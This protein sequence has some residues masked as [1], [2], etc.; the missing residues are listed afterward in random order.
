MCAGVF[1]NGPRLADPS[2]MGRITRVT[3]RAA[4]CCLALLSFQVSMARSQTTPGSPGYR[5]QAGDVLAIE[6]TGRNDISGQFTVTKEGQVNLPILGAVRAQGRTTGE[7]GTDISRR[8]SITSREIVQVSVTVL[9]Q[10]RRRNF[11]LGAVLLPGTF[12]FSDAP[13]V[14]EA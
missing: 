10:F 14:W 5:I 6:V 11:V 9:Q 13:T 7:I 8:I 3:L 2:G 4:A 12:S 1:T